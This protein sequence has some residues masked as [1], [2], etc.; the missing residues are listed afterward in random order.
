[1]QHRH[2]N[3]AR[4]T[5]DC[6]GPKPGRRRRRRHRRFRRASGAPPA[7]PGRSTAQ[8]ILLTLS[9]I[10]KGCAVGRRRGIR[11]NGDRPGLWRAGSSTKSCRRSASTS[12]WHSSHQYLSAPHS[13]SAPRKR[14]IAAGR[15][16]PPPPAAAAAAPGFCELGRPA[17]PVSPGLSGCSRQSCQR[18]AATRAQLQLDASGSN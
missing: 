13:R 14:P 5:A 16:C 15:G 2:R 6:E 9:P 17:L 1:M 3:C 11:Q 7:A 10:W 18:L 12:A 8:L 4:Q